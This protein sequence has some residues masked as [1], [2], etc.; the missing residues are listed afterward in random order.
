MI[1]EELT[2]RMNKMIDLM[3]HF[4]LQLLELLQISVVGSVSGMF[5]Y[6]F[7][8]WIDLQIRVFEIITCLLLLNLL[9]SEN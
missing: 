2:S 1:N 6:L 5:F 7:A 9:A 3:V 8:K 4:T